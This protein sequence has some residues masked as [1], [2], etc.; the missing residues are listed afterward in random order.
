MDPVA[1]HF[2]PITNMAVIQEFSPYHFFANVVA[3]V[4][5]IFLANMVNE[6]IT[7]SIV[8][9]TGFE[10]SEEK[11]KT[12][13]LYIST[14]VIGMIANMALIPLAFSLLDFEIS[15]ALSFAISAYS[16]SSMYAKPL[17]SSMQP[18]Q[19]A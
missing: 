3:S 14:L 19:T 2:A 12:M 7:G 5:G 13:A 17:F 15:W 11:W 9:L 6:V 16:A 8:V 18:E 10:E 4:T 1:I